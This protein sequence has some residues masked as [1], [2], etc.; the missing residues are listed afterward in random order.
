MIDYWICIYFIEIFINSVFKFLLCINSNSLQHLL[1]HLAE[2][3]FNQIQPGTMGWCKYK[4]VASFWFCCKVVLNLF[5][6]NIT[7]Y[8]LHVEEPRKIQ[9]FNRIIKC[10]DLE[11][12]V[13]KFQIGNHCVMNAITL[14]VLLAEIAS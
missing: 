6:Q 3:A 8:V 12:E 13:M 2:K 10:R 5:L 7:M 11:G 14:K 9:G 4:H 1:C